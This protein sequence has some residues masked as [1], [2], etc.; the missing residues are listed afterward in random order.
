MRR[1]LNIV[2]L[3]GLVWSGYWYAAGWGLR[4]S[5]SGWFAAQQARGWQADYADISTSGYPARHVTLIE[6]PAL[7]DPATGAAWQADWLMLDS[8]AI[9]PGHQT[10]R[11]PATPQRLSHFDRTLV[12]ATEDMRADLRLAPGIELVLEQLSLASGPWSVAEDGAAVMVASDL[13]LSMIQADSP[14]TYDIEIT[15]DD[16]SPGARLR[17]LLASSADLPQSF[18]TLEL[19]AQV[20]FDTRWDR[21]ALERRRPQPVSIALDLA[22]MRWGAL[23]VYATGALS[24]DAEGVPTGAIALKAENW[25]EMLAMAEAA[26]ALPPQAIAPAERMLGMLAGLGGNSRAL[27]VQLN[28]RD[29]YVALGPVPLGPAP[30]LILR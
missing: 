1:V 14:E 16:F 8:P 11:F 7:A 2:I 23:H 27:D 12:V 25:R 28:F 26:G 18:E 19:K 15:A 29:G 6:S 9:W 13:G 22:E 24:V 21:A 30:R 4:S 20:Q 17:R 5:V 10:V 3:V